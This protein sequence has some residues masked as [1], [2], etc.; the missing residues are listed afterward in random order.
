MISLKDKTW[1]PYL[2]GVLTGLTLIL[3][4]LISGKYLGAST[5][6]AIS[7][8]MIEKIVSP[9]H[10]SGLEYFQKYNLQ[11]NWQWMFVFGI[12]IGSFVSSIIS[13]SFTRQA[14][15]PMWEKRFGSSIVK[16]AVIA[17]IGGFLVLYG[18]RL[19][20][21]CP[22][23]HGLSGF[24]QMSI[25]GYVSLTCFFVGGA[26]VARILYNKS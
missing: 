21:G 11:I 1:S 15:P 4:V 7:A 20:G 18:A 22:S 10:V 12:L 6:F 25:S 2:A 9:D 14:I 8:G 3:S 24:A 26:V 16:R 17:F 13:K 19:A 23:G 5:T